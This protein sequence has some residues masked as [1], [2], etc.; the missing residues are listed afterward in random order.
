[1]WRSSVVD[2][3]TDGFADGS[4]IPY[5][6]YHEIRLELYANPTAGITIMFEQTTKLDVQN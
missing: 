5:S 2:Y 3:I 6:H 1:M 4:A